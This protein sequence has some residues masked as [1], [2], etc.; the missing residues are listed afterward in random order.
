MFVFYHVWLIYAISRQKVCLNLL[1]FRLIFGIFPSNFFSSFFVIFLSKFCYCFFLI[2]S[3][4]PMEFAYVFFSQNF[5]AKNVHVT[6]KFFLAKNVTF[7]KMFSPIFNHFL[8]CF[9]NCYFFRLNFVIL[10][11]NFVNSDIFTHSFCYC[12]SFLYKNLLFSPKFCNLFCV[13]SFG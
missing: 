11:P 2:L 6:I 1:F 7:F 13:I 12:F 8:F 4:F 3:F 5:G 9:K 10:S